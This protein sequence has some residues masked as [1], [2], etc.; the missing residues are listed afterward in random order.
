MAAA[1]TAGETDSIL[2]A[3]ESTFKAMKL[4]TYPELWGM[5]SRKSPDVIIGDVAKALKK[6]GNRVEKEEV[7]RDFAE[8]GA[9]SKDYWESYLTAFDPDAVL[10][11]SRWDM[12]LV[13]KKEAEILLQYRKAEQPARLKLFKE[14]GFWRVGLEETFSGRRLLK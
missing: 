3:A 13:G 8:G 1:E 14:N 5:L 10:E 2:S 9:L 12:G 11:H 4:R 7:G 6:A